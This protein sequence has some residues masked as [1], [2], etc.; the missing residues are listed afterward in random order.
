MAEES[1]LAGGAPSGPEVW[2]APAPPPVFLDGSRD[3]E[4]QRMASAARELGQLQQ[5]LRALNADGRPGR[6]FHRM[7]VAFPA[8]YRMLPA[9]Q[10]DPRLVPP[11]IRTSL[12]DPDLRVLDGF[13]RFSHG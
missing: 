6:A 5:E 3:A 11:E 4:A 13:A 1:P 12:F 2:P 9:G 7:G 8:T 10:L